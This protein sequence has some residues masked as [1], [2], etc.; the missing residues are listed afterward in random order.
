[1]LIPEHHRP[2]RNPSMRARA[3]RNRQITLLMI[4][5]KAIAPDTIS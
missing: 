3:T 4:A 1:M 5:I 2:K